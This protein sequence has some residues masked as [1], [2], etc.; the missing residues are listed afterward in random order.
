MRIVINTLNIVDENLAGVG[1]FLRNI[2]SEWLKEELPDVSITILHSKGIDAYR[3]FEVPRNRQVRM[4]ETPVRGFFTRIFY[5]QLI[6]PFK[7]RSF[8]VYYSGTQIIPFLA[9]IVSRKTRLVITIHDLISFY[10]PGKY[11]PLRRLY[12]KYITIYGARYADNVMVVSENTLNDV[13]RLTGT[14]ASKIAVVYNFLTYKPDLT[15]L[16]REN[17]FLVISTIEPGKNIENTLTGFKIFLDK[18]GPKDFKLYWVGKIGWGYDAEGLRNMIGS[19][20]LTDRVILP[21]FISEEEKT[22]LLKTCAAMVYLSF[23]EG[24]GIPVLEGLYH[25]KPCVVSNSSSLPEVAGQA[26]ILC[27]EQNPE[28][29]A[30][31]MNLIFTKPEPFLR[32]IPA[33]LAKFAREKQVQ[34]FREIVE[35]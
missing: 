32:E 9:R 5:E 31:A 22:R 12:V 13:V 20:G 6:L 11:P 30:D 10:V 15:N 4:I 21:G 17:F 26:G 29:I 2:L 7:V 34:R 23:Y 16:L 8:D 19:K 1:V 35:R 24:F 18:Y 14:P 28:S 33:Q 3:V 27:D 25:N